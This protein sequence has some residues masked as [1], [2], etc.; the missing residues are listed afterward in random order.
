MQGVEG[1]G[2]GVGGWNNGNP[3]F[4]EGLPNAGEIPVLRQVRKS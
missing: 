2:M 1:E 4:T 3:I